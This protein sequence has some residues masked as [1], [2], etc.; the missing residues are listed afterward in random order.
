MSTDIPSLPIGTKF[1]FDS[2]PNALFIT[3]NPFYDSNDKKRDFVI[4]DWGHDNLGTRYNI[5]YF[6]GIEHNCLPLTI[7]E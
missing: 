5:Y 4:L 6:S 3:I 1:K 2:N 7:Q